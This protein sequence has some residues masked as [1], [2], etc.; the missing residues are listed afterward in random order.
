MSSC[1]LSRSFLIRTHHN[2]VTGSHWQTAEGSSD[3]KSAFSNPPITTPW[4][5]FIYSK[6]AFSFSS[7]LSKQLN[8]IFVKNL[9]VA[10]T[11]IFAPKSTCWAPCER[12]HDWE[13]FRRT[14][15]MD[16]IFINIDGLNTRIWAFKP[17]AWKG[18][19][20]VLLENRNFYLF[21]CWKLYKFHYLGE[22]EKMYLTLHCF[23]GRRGKWLHQVLQ[24]SDHGCREMHT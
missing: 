8:W 2:L 11:K 5:D 7:C 1:L 6:T 18:K 12:I 9:F 4:A 17:K 19:G 10:K 22:H 3:T 15:Q 23:W 13:N 20:P 21:K 24:C 14:A 16:N